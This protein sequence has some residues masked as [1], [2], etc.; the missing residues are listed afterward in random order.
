MHNLA[1]FLLQYNQ[2]V[3]Y[4]RIGVMNEGCV[5]ALTRCCSSCSNGS[6]TGCKDEIK[7]IS[8]AGNDPTT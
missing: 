6:I 4:A 7:I 5:Q 1:Y 2:R 3:K 8:I